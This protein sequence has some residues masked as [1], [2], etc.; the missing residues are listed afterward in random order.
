MASRF[1]IGAYFH[2]G[3]EEREA[4]TVY[5][6]MYPREV[7]ERIFSLQYKAGRTRSR[8]YPI[9]ESLGGVAIAFVLGW[10]GY[11]VLL[12]ETTVGQFSISALFCSQI[13]D[14]NLL[15]QIGNN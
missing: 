9:L 6:G 15:E 11:Q 5:M 2:F 7:F 12:G 14:D 3:T 4:D 1:G 13:E 10:G 8:S